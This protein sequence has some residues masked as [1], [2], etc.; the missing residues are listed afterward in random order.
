MKIELVWISVENLEKSL[1]YYT[2]VLGFEISEKAA[3]FWMG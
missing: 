3:D 1:E 2:Q